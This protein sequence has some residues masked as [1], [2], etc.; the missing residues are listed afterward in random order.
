MVNRDIIERLS[1]SYSGDI[2][3]CLDKLGVWGALEGFSFYGKFSEQERFCGPAITVQFVPSSARV[4]SRRYHKAVDESAG[5]VL[6][7]DTQGAVGSCTGELM[8]AGAKM[9]GAV[10]SIVNGT[11]RDSS[12]LLEL[13]YPVFAKGVLP[14]GAIGRMED[15]ATQVGI[16]IGNTRVQPGDIIFGDRDGVIVIPQNLAHLVAQMADALGKLENNFR[17]EIMAGKPLF[18]VFSKL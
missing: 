17:A 15:V 5:S 2:H 6:V 7:I 9:H 10:G 4:I 1:M 11:I 16:Q 14:V 8:C 18:D 3:D 12:R 13:N